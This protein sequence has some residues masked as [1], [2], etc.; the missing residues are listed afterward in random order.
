MKKILFAV[1]ITG[2][3]TAA[4]ILVLADKTAAELR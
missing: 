3:A 4:A 2:I 1:I